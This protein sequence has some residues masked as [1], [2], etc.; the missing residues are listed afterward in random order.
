MQNGYR[1]EVIHKMCKV[2][3]GYAEVIFVVINL[4]CTDHIVCLSE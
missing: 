4:I 1:Y 3:A 2:F